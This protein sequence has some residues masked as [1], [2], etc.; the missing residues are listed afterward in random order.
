MVREALIIARRTLP[1]SAHRFSPKKFTQHQ[2][3]A[4][5]VLKEF[6]RTDY[7]GGEV[8]L[9][10]NVPLRDEFGLHA[11]PDYSTL[12]N[13]S[14][15]LLSGGRAQWLSDETLQRARRQRRLKRVRFAA[16]DCSGFES[17]RASHY[18]VR[19]RT[20]EGKTTEKWHT[21]TYR[22]FPEL[23]LICDCRSHLILAATTRRG[24]S[25]DF[26]CWEGG[27]RSAR[28]RVALKKL[29][30]DAGFRRRMDSPNGA[31]CL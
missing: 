11:A 26:D 6:L 28:R 16:V 22:R 10:E 3:F 4:C 24:P 25:P 20:R 9:R 12:Q 19:R 27:V 29:L 14:R 5:L 31:T 30:A 1:A 15:R 18:F 17:H 13:A 7:R 23:A 21:M 2:L 8:L